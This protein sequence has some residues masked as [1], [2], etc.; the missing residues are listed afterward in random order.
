MRTFTKVYTRKYNIPNTYESYCW[1]K[2]IHRIAFCVE[3]RQTLAFK[4]NKTVINFQLTYIHTHNLCQTQRFLETHVLVMFSMDVYECM[5]VFRY[6]L[7]MLCL[8]F[9]WKYNAVKKS[10]KDQKSRSF[11][12]IIYVKDTGSYT[13]IHFRLVAW[14]F[15]ALY[16]FNI[17]KIYVR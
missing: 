10:K 1:W 3:W 6:V 5:Y 13:K 17:T 14:I 12:C 8:Y 16:T 2:K 4:N 9:S 7:S 11:F 15:A